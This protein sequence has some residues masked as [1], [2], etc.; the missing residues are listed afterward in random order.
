MVIS[1]QFKLV[2]YCHTNLANILKQIAFISAIN[3]AGVDSYQSCCCKPGGHLHK[4]WD[5]CY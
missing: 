2:D 1:V 3:S 4:E 5:T